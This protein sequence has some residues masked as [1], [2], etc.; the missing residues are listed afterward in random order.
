MRQYETAFLIAPNLSEEDNAK[1]IEQMTEIVSDKKGKIVNVD[2]WGK[3]RLAYP[4]QKFHEAYYVFFVYE[5]EPAV[6]TELERRFKQTEAILR[7]LTVRNEA[8]KI[9]KEKRKRAAKGKKKEVKAKE[10]VSGE[11]EPKKDPEIPATG[12]PREEE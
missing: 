11:E 7:Y 4:V 5:G 9:V 2:K 6:P 10:A 8:K 1:L 3:R 12:E